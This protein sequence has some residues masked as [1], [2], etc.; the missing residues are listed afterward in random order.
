MDESWVTPITTTLDI[1][2]DNRHG[3]FAPLSSCLVST[4]TRI[5]FPI[6]WVDHSRARIVRIDVHFSRFETRNR[7]IR[8]RSHTAKKSLATPETPIDRF[9][10][11][12]TPGSRSSC[13]EVVSRVVTRG[14]I[15]ATESKNT[16]TFS[17]YRSDTPFAKLSTI[18]DTP[19]NSFFHV[20]AFT[21]CTVTG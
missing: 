4:D 11:R 21:C 17:I 15:N 19:K 10:Y 14:N 13:N 8:T 9:D 12:N 5:S 3:S 6:A 2:Y 1:R 18:V 20:T 16:D 7:N